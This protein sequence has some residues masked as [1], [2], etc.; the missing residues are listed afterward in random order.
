MLEGL[1]QGGRP[2]TYFWD[3]P[4]LSEYWQKVQKEIKT[5]LYYHLFIDIPLDPSHFILGI[6][7]DNLEEN[8]HS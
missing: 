6:L 4:K 8:S 2:H 7:P 3:C 1:W 5:L